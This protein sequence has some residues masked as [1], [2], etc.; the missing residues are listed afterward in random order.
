VNHAALK[1]AIDADPALAGLSDSE[2][3]NALNARDVPGL[4]PLD[5]LNAKADEL[6]VTFALLVAREN[7]LVTGQL[8]AAVE[9]SLR[10]F[11][12]RYNHIDLT[13]PM[14]ATVLAAL[15]Q[16]GIVTQAQSDQ[17]LAM[18]QNRSSRAERAL[19]RFAS[20]E[21]VAAALRGADSGE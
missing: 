9:Q 20:H 12:A 5:E 19:G 3:A 15:G 10:L 7:P 13:L 1:T 18:S 21:D 14:V 17:L 11:D 6:G 8:K 4:V 2:I 16:A